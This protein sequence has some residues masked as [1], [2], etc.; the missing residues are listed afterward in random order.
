RV[1]PTL[2]LPILVVILSIF[3]LG[4]S[5]APPTAAPK[6]SATAA[7]RT[8]TLTLWHT[9]TGDRRATLEAMARDFQDTYP[10]LTVHPVYVGSRDDMTKQMNAAIAL[11]TQPD[12]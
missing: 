12:L 6:T 5:A 1:R 9:F 10:D 7:P 4:C 8:T 2:A 3:A 11:G